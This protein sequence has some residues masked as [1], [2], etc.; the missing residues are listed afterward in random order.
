MC[1]A[2]NPRDVATWVRQTGYQS[3]L[4]RV[5]C[6]GQDNWHAP[7]AFPGCQGG[8]SGGRDDDV[9]RQT[10]QLLDEVSLL[11]V[12]SVQA[13]VLKVD[14]LAL[15]PTEFVQ[16][17]KERRSRAS[18]VGRIPDTWKPLRWDSSHR[19]AAA[20]QGDRDA[21]QSQSYWQS[22]DTDVTRPWWAWASSA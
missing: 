6:N 22:H 2:R 4:H 7:R 18:R 12:P 15:E 17:L 14:G 19:E 20:E 21:E 5:A 8:R 13:A 11:L 10:V 9:K 16:P 1:P 3:E